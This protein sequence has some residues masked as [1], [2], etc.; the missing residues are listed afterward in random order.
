[1]RERGLRPLGV[2]D[3]DTGSEISTQGQEGEWS[4][5]RSVLY[6]DRACIRRLLNTPLLCPS[7]L[8]AVWVCWLTLRLRCTPCSRSSPHLPSA[9][10]VC[11]DTDSSF[12]L[13][14]KIP[15]TLQPATFH[16]NER[17]VAHFHH[18]LPLPLRTSFVTQCP[19]LDLLQ[20]S[21]FRVHPSSP[22]SCPSNPIHEALLQPLSSA[23]LCQCLCSG[24]LFWPLCPSYL[25]PLFAP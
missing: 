8:F 15:A 17:A 11:L 3:P 14:I 6:A 21:C 10:T 4:F 9:T 16:M 18:T 2:L 13:Q 23:D 24:A 25:F 20:R 19:F 7:S 12:R 1:M 22:S 5:G